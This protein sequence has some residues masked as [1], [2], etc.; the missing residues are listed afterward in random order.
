MTGMDDRIDTAEAPW[1]ALS[2]PEILAT[3][4]AG[5]GKI[6]L[7]IADKPDGKPR[8]VLV[9]IPV[10]GAYSETW[11]LNCPKSERIVRNLAD[12]LAKRD[13]E[14][15][16]PIQMCD[17]LSRNLPGELETILANCLAHGRR[18]FVEVADHVVAV[19][20]LDACAFRDVACGDDAGALRVAPAGRLHGPDRE[21]GD[22]AVSGAGAIASRTWKSWIDRSS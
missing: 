6:K 2:L 17:A 12:L 13:E 7:M 5:D 16:A 15:G 18:Q 21:R 22:G 10:L 3:A 14:L 19:Q 20:D 9:S 8:E 1:R 11:P 4:E